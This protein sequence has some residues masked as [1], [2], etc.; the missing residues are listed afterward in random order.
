MMMMRPKSVTKILNS[1]SL[2]LFVLSVW[3]FSV[4]RTDCYVF[5]YCLD[6]MTNKRRTL[7]DLMIKHYFLSSPRSMSMGMKVIY[8]CPILSL[9]SSFLFW[10]S[11]II[12][13]SAC[14]DEKA[15]EEKNENKSLVFCSTRTDRVS[16][17]QLLR[18]FFLS[19]LRRPGRA[20]AFR[21]PPGIHYSRKQRK[22]RHNRRK[23]KKIL[24]F[25]ADPTG[26]DDESEKM[27]ENER[28]R[29][30]AEGR[31]KERFND[32]QIQS[33]TFIDVT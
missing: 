23:E 13:S 30:E 27:T 21:V 29:D 24:S 19:L 18:R 5:Q 28:K 6:A 2:S 16:L 25:S 31:R 26:N 10:R 20:I 1:L 7:I 32:F 15:K 17:L 33:N 22:I 3:L 9:S 12:F 11:I 14:G 4:I 8:R